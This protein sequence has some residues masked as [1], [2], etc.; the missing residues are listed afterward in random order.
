MQSGLICIRFTHTRAELIFAGSR[1]NQSGAD[2]HRFIRTRAVVI[3][4]GSRENQS[5]LIC[6]SAPVDHSGRFSP[7][8]VK[9]ISGRLPLE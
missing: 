7:I 9:I 2:L 4:A 1:E 5:G 8:F 6:I 3:F